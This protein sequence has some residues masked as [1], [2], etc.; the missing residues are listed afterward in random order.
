MSFFYS[1]PSKKYI[2][3]LFSSSFSF[4]VSIW[5]N[6]WKKDVNLSFN[7]L[8]WS[9]DWVNFSF[10]Y[11]YSSWKS[12]DILI[13]FWIVWAVVGE[14]WS[15]VWS[16]SGRKR[17]GVLWLDLMSDIRDALRMVNFSSIRLFLF[18]LLF[19]DFTLNLPV[20]N[21]FTSY[22]SLLLW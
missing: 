13:R 9:S 8:N 22:L 15:S 18:P 2:W 21:G 5:P 12:S 11:L 3:L 10:S 14:F 16:V 20:L 7:S 6:S 1:S 19:W 17:C 4:T